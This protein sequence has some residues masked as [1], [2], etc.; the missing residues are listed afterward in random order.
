MLL[1]ESVIPLVHL[2]EHLEEERFTFPGSLI[3]QRSDISISVRYA[4]ID[5][6]RHPS[7]MLLTMM[8]TRLTQMIV[9]VN[10]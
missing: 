1:E 10:V 8:T 6:T 9:T 7:H 2:L 5:I 4:H 3:E